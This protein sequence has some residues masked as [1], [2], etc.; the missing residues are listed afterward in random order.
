MRKFCDDKY[1]ILFTHKGKP[2]P[3]VSSPQMHR[4]TRRQLAHL[5]LFRKLSL[6]GYCRPLDLNAVV[7]AA[8]TLLFFLT[9]LEQRRSNDE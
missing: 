3:G 5:V 6:A 7:S 4:M 2:L 8:D 1:L 9:G